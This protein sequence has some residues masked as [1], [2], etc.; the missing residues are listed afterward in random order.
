MP[1]KGASHSQSIVDLQT[2]VVAAR[3]EFVASMSQLRAAT[4]PAALVQRSA[5]AVGNWFID[6]YGGI[7][8]ERVAIVSAVVVGYVALRIARRR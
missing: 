1:A 3:E 2:E 4:T 7:R 6:E 8:P 5:R